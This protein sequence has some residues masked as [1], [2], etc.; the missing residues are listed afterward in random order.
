MGSCAVL[1]RPQKSRMEGCWNIHAHTS[2]QAICRGGKHGRG[3]TASGILPF[4]SLRSTETRCCN[5][6]AHSAHVCGTH[7]LRV[8]CW[9]FRTLCARSLHMVHLRYDSWIARR[10]SETPKALST[11]P[12]TPMTLVFHFCHMSSARGTIDGR[13]PVTCNRVP[14]REEPGKPREDARRGRCHPLEAGIY[15]CGC[16][17]YHDT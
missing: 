2:M 11:N 5:E 16:H 9:R 10:L 1:Q 17:R 15:P 7:G 3:H 12:E 13:G 4:H 8:V 14:D 6:G